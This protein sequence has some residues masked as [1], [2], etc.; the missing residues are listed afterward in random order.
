MALAGKEGKLVNTAADV[1]DVKG[2]TLD[3]GVDALEDTA[4]GDDWK[5][6]VAGL[7]EWTASADAIWAV[8]TDTDGQTAMQTSFL[9][10]T[11]VTLKF[12]VDDTN[13]YSGSAIITSM[14]IEDQVD[15]LVLC[16][17]EFQGSGALSYT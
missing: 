5:T 3:I 14:S 10:G 17:F 12:Y 2:W 6:Y 1:A 11:A 7:N 4:L 15:D 8:A 16:S 13:Y 9:A